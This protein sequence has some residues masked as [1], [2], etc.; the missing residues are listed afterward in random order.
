MILTGDFRVLHYPP[1]A[2]MVSIVGR[3]GVQL[4]LCI[5]QALRHV[6]GRLEQDRDA[7]QAV[8]G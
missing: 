6:L 2:I 7:G 5:P 3:R 4:H 1:V 8:Q